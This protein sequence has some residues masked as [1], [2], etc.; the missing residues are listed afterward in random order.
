VGWGGRSLAG[1]GLVR[2]H[3]VERMELGVGSVVGNV[4]DWKKENEMK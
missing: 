2:V 3:V 1:R 4:S